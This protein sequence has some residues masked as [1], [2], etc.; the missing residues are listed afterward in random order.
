MRFGDVKAH[1]R[2]PKI[3][4]ANQR[5]AFRGSVAE[6]GF[7]SVPLAYIS[8]RNGNAITWADGHLR[9]SEVADYEGSVAIL[10][11]DDAEADKLL[12]YA[13]PIAAMAEYESA[14]LDSLMRDVQTSDEALMAM[15][16]SMAEEA[17]LY[18][19]KTPVQ[20]PGPQIDKADALRRKWGVKSGDL[21]QL[22][23]HRLICGDCTDKA[24]VERLMQGEK[25][26]AANTDPPYNVGR[27]YTNET[28]DSKPTEEYEAFSRKWFSI[29]K[30]YCE[31][32]AFSCG[33]P[34]V[35]LWAKIEQWK[36]IIC[37]YKPGAM[38][39]SPFGFSNWEPV[40]FYGKA[41]KNGTDVINAP[42]VVSKDAAMEAHPVPKQL[43][44]ALKLMEMTTGEN[45]IVY[46]PFLGSG[47]TLI[48]CEQ[49]GRQ[50]RAAEISPAYVAVALERWSTATSCQPVRVE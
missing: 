22:R 40:L 31:S 3:H 38:L 48:A 13:D 43:D 11:I 1:P 8:A 24:T 14:Q 47:T 44:Y 35:Y 27:E 36:W 19:D 21:W 25:A 7:T 16:A 2:N 42:I 32:I 28:D 41:P 9:G 23:N 33:H 49:L 4:P 10:D 5:A 15:L 34:N 37:W 30:D 45:D 29:A 20:D 26:K 46:D 50:C 18:P 12:L 6:L 17:G 39:G